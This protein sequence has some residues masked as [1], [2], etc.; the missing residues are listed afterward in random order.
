VPTSITLPESIIKKLE[1]KGL[2]P[3]SF[4]IN[5]ILKELKLDPREEISIRLEIAEK[6]FEKAKI[7][8][9][10]GDV[11]QAS[12]KLYKTV[13]ECLKILAQIYKLPY[14]EEAIS[15]G[16]WWTQLLGK[17][18]RRLSKELNEPMLVDVWSRA[19]D[20]HV[21]GFHES[22]YTIEDITDEDLKN[23]EWLIKYTK[24]TVR[25]RLSSKS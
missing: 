13:E 9:K 23:I 22:K 25:K 16:R 5:V 20:I 3:E 15:E 17:T 24:E 7:Y 14:Y 19:Y 18:A 21:W 2:D 4:I 8:L 11:V 12:E 1:K 6:S 10:R